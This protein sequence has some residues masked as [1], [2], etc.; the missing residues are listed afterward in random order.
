[1]WDNALGFGGN[2]NASFGDS[3]VKGHCVVD[4]PFAMLEV[5]YLDETLD[6]HCL[7]RGFQSGASL[8]NLSQKIR[9]QALESLFRLSD[10]ENFNLG[11]EDG[12]HIAVPRSIRGDFSLFTAPSGE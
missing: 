5:P 11:L 8:V 2:G 12:A 7:S 4:G 9:P 1:M 6:P 3:I 10:Y